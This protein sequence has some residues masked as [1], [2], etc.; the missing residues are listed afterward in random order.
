VNLSARQFRQQEL[1]EVIQQALAESG[2]PPHL[3][4]LEITESLAMDDVAFTRQVIGSLRALGVHSSL[5][6][7]GTG[8]SS[9]SHLSTLPF[10]VLKI[11]RTF[12]GGIGR[13]SSEAAI[14][15][16]VIALGHELG[17]TVVAEGVET[18]EELAFVREHGCDQVQGFLFSRAVPADEATRLVAQGVLAP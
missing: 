14:V 8:Y 16:A 4:E 6:D 5:D 2:L 9:L 3:L 17:L 10:D 15:R 7:F 18:L 11:D 12:V 1:V 13:Q